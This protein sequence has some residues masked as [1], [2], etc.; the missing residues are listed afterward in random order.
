MHG[1][2]LIAPLAGFPI[3]HWSVVHAATVCSQIIV[4]LGHGADSIRPAVPA[5][6]NVEIVING[7]YQRG[8][9]S[10]IQRGA[11]EVTAPWFFVAP[12]DMPFLAPELY[13]EIARA[14]LETDC[15]AL[16]PSRDGVTGHPVF[17]SGSVW[18]DLQAADPDTRSMRAFL[19]RY[20]T[21]E[22][23]VQ[24]EAIHFDIDDDE[25]F[26]RLAGRADELL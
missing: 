1:T 21:C 24:S 7:D 22:V 13:R 26:R 6:D 14:S 5:L 12:A 20:P 10:S 9:F 17:V 25:G 16:F 15:V 18:D 2:K 11:A 23:P 4:V 19:R 8:M 3:I